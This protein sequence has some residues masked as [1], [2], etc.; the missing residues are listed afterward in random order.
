[1]NRIKEFAKR[2]QLDYTYQSDMVSIGRLLEQTNTP[3]KWID[4]ADKKEE[5]FIQS[6]VIGKNQKPIVLGLKKHSSDFVVIDGIKR[7][8]SLN[9]FK[10]EPFGVCMLGDVIYFDELSIKEKNTF[11][12]CKLEVITIDG[13]VNDSDIETIREYFNQTNYA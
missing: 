7:L 1:M 10:E 8:Q 3:S 11:N 2:H 5:E 4:S 9:F 12:S 6:L 13:F